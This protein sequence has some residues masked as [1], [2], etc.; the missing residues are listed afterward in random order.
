MIAATIIPFILLGSDS[1]VMR[2]LPGMKACK[3]KSLFCGWAICILS[4]IGL[5][6][7]IQYIFGANK[8][9]EIFFGTTQFTNYVAVAE[10]LLIGAL[11][12]NF[13]KLWFRIKDQTFL[14]G[15]IVSMQATLSFLVIIFSVIY[16]EN[17]FSIL[18]YLG[19]ADVFICMTLIIRGV[20]QSKFPKPNFSI[21]PAIFSYGLPVFPAAF[22]M[23]GLGY[24]DRFFLV[25]SS[26]L[27]EV[28]IYAVS[29]QVGYLAIQFLS[30]PF[31]VM[32]PSKTAEYFNAQK[33]E[34][35]QN[36]F[37]KSLGATLIFGIPL[38]V[39]LYALGGDFLTLISGESFIS[40]SLV[41]PIIALAY[42]LHM[43]AS[44][45]DN[46][47]GLVNKQVL[48]TLAL[49]VALLVNIIANFFLIP[50]FSILGA[51]S[52][53]LIA[54]GVQFLLSFYFA[55]KFNLLQSNYFFVIKV[56]L[57]SCIMCLLLLGIN[58]HLPHGALWL[59]VKI[60][61][62]AALYFIL[63][64]VFRVIPEKILGRIR[65]DIVGLITN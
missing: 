61:I 7:C 62:G 13:F 52:A 14:F 22:A 63:I 21:L 24:I 31:W 56:I 3:Q 35:I 4:I 15:L 58:T 65:E 1:G 38:V 51:A 23:W 59:L 8:I 27:V 55:S 29:Y 49:V 44:Y 25:K 10:L 43:V 50:T 42:L 46:Y 48:G 12:V 64:V 60:F 45:Y 36:L 9:S 57:C 28:G 30:N 37:D 19:V 53:T 41:L 5:G 16:Q 47:L 33:S 40:G 11:G 54:F 26:N 6:L 32:Y 39:G 2:Y 20:S 17:L 18:L 34:L